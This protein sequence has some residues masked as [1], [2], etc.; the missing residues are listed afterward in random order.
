MQLAAGSLRPDGEV[1]RHLGVARLSE[2]HELGRITKDRRATAGCP[3]H[4]PYAAYNQLPTRLLADRHEPEIQH[5]PVKGGHSS[6]RETPLPRHVG[7]DG[8]HGK[9]HPYERISPN[10]TSFTARNAPSGGAKS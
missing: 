5:L 4:L 1:H 10:P 9:E 8:S 2:R 6:S 7:R 3:E